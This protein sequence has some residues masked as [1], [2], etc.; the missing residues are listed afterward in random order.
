MKFDDKY[1]DAE[2]GVKVSV[3]LVMTLMEE[4]AR[5]CFICGDETHWFH[6]ES[7]IHICSEECLEQ[8]VLAN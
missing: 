5:P 2:P 3:D 7:I 4:Q 6:R 8:H 1:R